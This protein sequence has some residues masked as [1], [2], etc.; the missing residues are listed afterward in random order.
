MCRMCCLGCIKWFSDH[1]TSAERSRVLHDAGHLIM[2]SWQFWTWISPRY[3]IHVCIR[4]WVALSH[5]K[6]YSLQN[7]VLDVEYH[8]CLVCLHST[9]QKKGNGSWKV[10]EVTFPPSPGCRQALMPTPIKVIQKQNVTVVILIA[11]R[12]RKKSACTKILLFCTFMAIQ[13]ETIGL[14]GLYCEF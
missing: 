5:W 8:C 9:L 13:N 2:T 6:A 3:L 12:K 14:S 11:V 1:S 4:S 10:R 7:C